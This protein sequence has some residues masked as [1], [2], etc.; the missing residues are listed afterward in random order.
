VRL[1]NVETPIAGFG[2]EGSKIVGEKPKEQFMKSP[3]RSEDAK[4]AL[5]SCLPTLTRISPS[6][7]E[8]SYQ[9]SISKNSFASLRVLSILLKN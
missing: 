7:S 6:A 5:K 8:C 3:P 2:Q 4:S 9:Y 1:R